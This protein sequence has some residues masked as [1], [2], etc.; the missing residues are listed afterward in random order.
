MLRLT[1]QLN[2]MFMRVVTVLRFVPPGWHPPL[3]NGPSDQ[4]PFVDFQRLDG[5]GRASFFLKASGADS[6][7][8]FQQGYGAITSLPNGHRSRKHPALRRRS[9]PMLCR[10]VNRRGWRTTDTSWPVCFRLPAL[11]VPQIVTLSSNSPPIFWL[12]RTHTQVSGITS[13]RSRGISTLQM[14]HFRISVSMGVP[15]C[16]RRPWRDAE[17]R[18]IHRF[19]PFL[20]DDWC[21]GPS[22]AREYQD[23]RGM[24]SLSHHDTKTNS[25]SLPAWLD[26][27]PVRGH[28]ITRCPKVK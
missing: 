20:A 13:S 9:T 28:Q 23:R 27:Q 15:F 5:G 22:V 8:G 16:M 6:D 25:L 10:Y 26:A 3:S 7:F 4:L 1:P 2:P 18:N 19:P 11:L 17:A 24:S 14:R 21:S 12:H